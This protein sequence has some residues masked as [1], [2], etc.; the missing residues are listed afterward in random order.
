MGKRVLGIF[1]DGQILKSALVHKIEDSLVLERMET[2]K[3]YDSL[4]LSETM[5]AL[6]DDEENDVFASEEEESPFELDGDAE[7]SMTVVQAD[8]N[9]DV[10]LDLIKNMIPKGT[11]VAINIC[12]TYT[13]YKDIPALSD[14]KLKNIK[15]DIWKEFNPGAEL[16]PI[17][18]NVGY[19][20]RHDG[21]YV[22]MYHDD[23]IVFSTLLA[24]TI[25]Y[26]KKQPPRID[27]IDTIEFALAHEVS[28]GFDLGENEHVAVIVFA[29]RFTKIFFMLGNE[30]ELVLPTIH[31]GSDSK[32]ICETI[33]SKILFEFDSGNIG[34]LHRM[35][36]VGDSE[37]V[38]AEQIFQE[39]LISLPIQR[40]DIERLTFASEI[41]TQEN[42]IKDYGV[43]IALAIKALEGR[44]DSLY[45]QNYLPRRIRDK[46]SVYK[47]AWH[48]MV[49][50]AL[51]F[52]CVMFLSYNSI[53]RSQEI[54]LAKE[55]IG[56]LDYKLQ[57]LASVEMEVDSLRFQINK[58]QAGASLLDSLLQNVTRWSPVMEI[59][60]DA[61][62]KVGN[63]SIVN[64]K[65]NTNNKFVVDAEVTDKNAVAELERFI[66]N[67]RV[68][69]V[70]TT[71]QEAG[72]NLRVQIECVVD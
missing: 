45:N 23:P 64:M 37:V 35:I 65:T 29:K 39:K 63:F 6:E 52:V 21:S 12:D 47:L 48:G 44:K 50:L 38:N 30:I 5:D 7:N 2:V 49:T 15:K 42:R 13:V 54:Q 56:E 16:D 1:I 34:P 31:E 40:F 17:T 70:V 51:L 43:A 72:N 68:L 62:R 8:S 69:S 18:E 66:N 26:T 55:S 28:Y 67:S 41:E 33:L 36:M 32:S 3:L 24:E 9:A 53:K 4:D 25:E 10:I 57:S 14:G 46:Q 59:F 20:K 27:L 22:G 61:H 11:S 60:S 58:L 19:F 71:Q